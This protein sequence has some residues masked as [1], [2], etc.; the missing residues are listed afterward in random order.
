MKKIKCL[1]LIIIIFSISNVYAID[2][3]TASEMARLKELA[4]NVEIKYDYKIIEYDED[5]DDDDDN[6]GLEYSVKLYNT[7]NEL[8]IFAKEFGEVKEFN[9][10]YENVFY[11]GDSVQFT[12]LAYTP[13]LCIDEVLKTVNITFPIY[14]R[15]YHENKEKCSLYPNFKYCK[16]FLDTSEIETSTIDKE[17]EKYINDLNGNIINNKSIPKYIIYIAIGVGIIILGIGSYI[18]IKKRRV[19]F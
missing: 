10:N 15:Y 13:N 19:D 17:F 8:K 4:N 6:I 18:F 7:S 2:E 11:E 5:E 9:E 3:C 12:I 16:E 1:I 14:N